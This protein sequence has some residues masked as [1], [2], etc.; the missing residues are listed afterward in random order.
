MSFINSVIV[1]LFTNGVVF[2]ML[3]ILFVLIC[4]F[5]RI[6]RAASK[7]DGSKKKE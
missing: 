5:T 2:V 1:G 4:I 3:L 7:P 6:I